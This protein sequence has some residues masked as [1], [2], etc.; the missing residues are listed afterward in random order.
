MCGIFGYV[1]ERP[2]ATLSASLD[3]AIIALRHRGPDDQGTLERNAGG[4]HCGMAFTRLA[5]LD[6]SPLGHQPMV[7][8]D[9]R[10]SMVFNGEVFNFAEIR[11]ELET[12]GI[13]IRST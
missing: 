10:Y 8:D 11:R 3:D 13:R 12:T 7:C 6:L 1:T 9:G 4:V 5:I 2:E